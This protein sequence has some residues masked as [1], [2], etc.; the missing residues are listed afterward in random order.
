MILDGG[1]RGVRVMLTFFS[2]A[3][4]HY[5]NWFVSLA[6]YCL[7][8]SKYDDNDNTNIAIIITMIIKIVVKAIMQL[9]IQVI[10]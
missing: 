8:Q 6:D 4:L 2:F 9:C 7:R 10:T 5:L 3:A 1:V